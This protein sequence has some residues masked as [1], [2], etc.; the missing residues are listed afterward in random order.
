MSRSSA[1]TVSAAADELPTPLQILD[2]RG[3][4]LTVS[5]YLALVAHLISAGIPQPGLVLLPGHE[6][7]REGHHKMRGKFFTQEVR[8][9]TLYS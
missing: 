9:D 4:L 3:L 2:G 1:V 8:H 6:R 7:T 5:A